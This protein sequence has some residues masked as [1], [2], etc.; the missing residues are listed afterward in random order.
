M[1]HS[2]EEKYTLNIFSKHV[3]ETGSSYYDAY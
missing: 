2:T 1:G 3:S